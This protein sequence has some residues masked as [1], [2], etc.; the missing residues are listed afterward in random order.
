MNNMEPDVERLRAARDML[1][2]D[3]DRGLVQLQNLTDAG[4]AMAPLCLGW[5]YQNGDGLPKDEDRAEKF[6]QL[7]LSRGEASASYY[8]G[9][10]YSKIGRHDDSSL[11]YKAGV[12][13]GYCPSMYCL[14]MNILSEDQTNEKM[15]KA[16][17][18]LELASSKGQVFAQRSLGSLY[19][20]GKFGISRIPFGVYLT[21]KS[22]IFGAVIAMRNHQD[23]RLLA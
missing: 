14:A 11:A 15:T 9:H 1:K 2:V 21:V 19:M 8:L 12:D 5:A 16:R 23:E 22:I 6:Y 18:L 20:H 3:P 4:S 10:F 13:I 7:A 17:Q